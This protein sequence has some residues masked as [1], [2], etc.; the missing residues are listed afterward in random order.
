M[1]MQDAAWQQF[2]QSGQVTDYLQYCN[3]RNMVVGTAQHVRKG[4]QNASRLPR[5]RSGG[6]GYGG[7]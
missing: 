7:K 1:D 6:Q 2:M 3:V 4:K 5:T